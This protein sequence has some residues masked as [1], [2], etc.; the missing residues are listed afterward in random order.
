MA[1]KRAG[2]RRGDSLAAG[3]KSRKAARLVAV[4]ATA[5]VERELVGTAEAA[6]ILG[7]RP[8]YVRQLARDGEIWSDTRFGQRCP[9]YDAIELRGRATKI[10]TERAAGKRQGR[11]PSGGPDA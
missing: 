11:P 4:D 10:A 2:R 5:N 6:K 8:E 9:V 3:A 1:K 7:L